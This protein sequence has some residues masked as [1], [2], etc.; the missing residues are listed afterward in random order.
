LN[1][2]I[3]LCRKN[4]RYKKKSQSNLFIANQLETRPDFWNLA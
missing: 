3:F 4:F 2:S 1:S